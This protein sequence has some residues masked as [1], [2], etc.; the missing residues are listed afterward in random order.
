MMQVDRHDE[1]GI[2]NACSI[3]E[4]SL[5]GSYSNNPAFCAGKAGMGSFLATPPVCLLR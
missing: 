1:T 3:Q 4:P 2:S 5:S